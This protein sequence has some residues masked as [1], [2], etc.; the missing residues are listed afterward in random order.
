MKLPNKEI[1]LSFNN[2][3]IQLFNQNAPNSIIKLN[4][5]NSLIT[6][7]INSFE[8][9]L[10]ALFASILYNNYTKN[11]LSS[12]EGFYASVI[13]VYLASLGFDIIGKDVTNR[14]RIDLTLFIDDKI[15]II[16]FK[17][18]SDSDALEQIKSKNYH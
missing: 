13:Y 2:M 11:S 17:V 4:L 15:Y 16:E 14:G 8:N 1:K 18:G 6:G 7:D 12:Y 5:Y 3:L 10:I 9:S